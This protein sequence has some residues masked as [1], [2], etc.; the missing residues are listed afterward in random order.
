[1][2]AISISSSQH[3]TGWSFKKRQLLFR[4]RAENM[5]ASE[6]CCDLAQHTP[7]FGN[8]DSLTKDTAVV[9]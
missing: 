5:M 1:M 3:Q 2:L 6:H 8:N 9:K 7:Y 4:R